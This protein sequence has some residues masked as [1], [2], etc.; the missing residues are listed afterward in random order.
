MASVWDQRLGFWWIAEDQPDRPAIVASPEGG[1][2]TP[3]SPG[4]AHQLV[5]LLRDRGVQPGD[6]VA[7][8]LPNGIGL[9]EWS[10]ACHEAGWYFIPLNTL[11]TG[12]EIATILRHSDA[13]VLV[14]DDRYAAQVATVEGR[15]AEGRVRHRSRRAVRAAPD[16]LVAVPDHDTGRAHAGVVLR[17]YV[18]DHRP[19]RRASAGRDP[20]PT[21][22][23]V[24]NDAA[25]FGRAFDFVPLG[26]PSPRVDRHAP[27]RRH[28]FWP[29]RARTW[30][31]GS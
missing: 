3:R 2:P 24:A 20:T 14:T 31:T 8:L 23:Q 9:V 7:A 6:A 16:A 15:Q 19:S 18:G 4:A 10:L 30:G 1:A 25:T 13:S 5:H 22:A 21:R 12:T 28:A 17:L 11:L 26:G 29:G 27:R